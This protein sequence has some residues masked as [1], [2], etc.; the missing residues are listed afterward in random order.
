MS[1]MFSS[2]KYRS[3]ALY[4]DEGVSVESLAHT[5]Y[6]LKQYLGSERRIKKIT[7]Q[8]I[9]NGALNDRVGVLIMPGGADLPYV[10][11]LSGL[12][13]Q[14]IKNYVTQGG[15]YFGI[16]AG[17]YY[18]SAEVVFDKGG[19]LEVIGSRELAF[20]PGSAVGPVLATYHYEHHQ[21]ARIAH[22]SLN[23]GGFNQKKIS[24]YYNGGGYFKD[25][26]GYPGVEIL[27]YYPHNLPAVIYTQYGKGRVLLSGVH[28]EYVPEL[29]DEHDVFLKPLLSDLKKAEHD[30][31]LWM[32]YQFKKLGLIRS[33]F[34]SC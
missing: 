8:D 9:L 12:G 25:A 16:C 24:V 7:A 11:K 5:V 4:Q 32:A 18:A 30:R 17:A 15:A 14:L 27:A 3:V 21:G 19:P 26:E 13:N 33:R 2:K 22:L 1:S 31:R 29:F 10:K 23:A 6:T 20:F 34:F 28:A